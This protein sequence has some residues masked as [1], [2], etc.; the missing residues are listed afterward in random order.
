ML[1]LLVRHAPSAA[2]DALVDEARR[3]GATPDELSELARA[4]ELALNVRDLMH[5]QQRR[6]A[7]LN[8]LVETARDLTL[9]YTLDALLKVITRRAR[10]L[11]HVDMSYISFPSE[12]ADGDYYVHTADGQT[13]A[14]TEGMTIPG[15]AGLSVD[16]QR[17]FAPFWS[18]DYLADDS[19]K[20]SEVIDDV[21]RAEG[22]HAIL[23]VP[24]RHGDSHFGV[25]YCAD[26]KIR[27]FTPDEIALLTSLADLAAVA[28][29]KSRAL[30]RVQA[31]VAELE[32]DIS[33]TKSR[34]ADGA[35][36]HDA[37]VAMTDLVLT[38]GDLAGL[39]RLAGQALGGTV[40][41]R[42]TDG[43]T[44]AA[45]GEPPA[46]LDEEGLTRA[47]LDAH[48]SRHTVSTADGCRVAA[49][50]AGAEDLGTLVLCPGPTGQTGDSE[51]HLLEHA[52]RTAGVLQLMVRSTSVAESQF[53]DAFFDDLLTTPPEKYEQLQERARRLSIDLDRPHVVVVARPEGGSQGRALVWA[54]SYTYRTGGL[55]SIR[56]GVIALLLP[57]DDAAR[58]AQAVSDALSPLLERPVT[59]GAAGPFT[60]LEPVRP[61]LQEALRCLD[62]LAALDCHGTTASAR[63]LG[64]LGVLL[65]DARDVSG[66]VADAIGPVLD[67]DA[68]RFTQLVQ[69]LE[70]Y[71]DAGSSPTHAADNLHVHPNTVSRRLERITELL[72]P[73]WQKP[74]R[75]LEIQ[76]ALR[77]Q[78]VRGT[79]RAPGQEG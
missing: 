14:L 42:G 53:R 57:G 71:F 4:R 69:T 16:V 19:I 46:E 13:T 10:A 74:A 24:L 3:I 51:R 15:S 33:G 79:L 12:A 39:A 77:L 8:A 7:G 67:Y 62:A 17:N 56:D 52:A 75:A 64:F 26:R 50:T 60:G 22:L 58:A 73:E 78:R 9:P 34:L 5:S 25:L 44:L 45:H 68:Q 2:Y 49:V 43:R 32:V 29:E 55:K 72:G 18:P 31:E 61:A 11:L 40:L 36:L 35:R 20:H 41:V 6:E 30:N 38:G 63:E 21:V 65:G 47:A 27:H 76:L 37:V 28:I 59:V 48:H 54:S 66:F 23:A 70:A 1:E